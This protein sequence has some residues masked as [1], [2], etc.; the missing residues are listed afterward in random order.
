MATQRGAKAPLFHDSIAMLFG[1]EEAALPGT[2][3]AT[4][5]GLILVPT[6]SGSAAKDLWPRILP[7]LRPLL[8]VGPAS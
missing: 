4:R 1:A 8:R 2:A 6:P 5:T 3:F 7:T